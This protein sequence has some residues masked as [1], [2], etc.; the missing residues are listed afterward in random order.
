[1]KV[2]SDGKS[3]WKKKCRESVHKSQKKKGV[4]AWHKV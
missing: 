2:E 1:M 3:V 4:K